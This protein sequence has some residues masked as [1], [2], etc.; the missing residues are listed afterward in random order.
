MW[1]KVDQLNDKQKNE[2]DSVQ[3]NEREKFTNFFNLI[4]NIILASRN[5]RM[6]RDDD[7]TTQSCFFLLSWNVILEY[8]GY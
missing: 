6:D 1:K 4:E 2:E 3:Q 5:V 7:E 8:A